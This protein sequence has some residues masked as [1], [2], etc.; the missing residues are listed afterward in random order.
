MDHRAWQPVE[1]PPH[2]ATTGNT[3]ILVGRSVGLRGLVSSALAGER[4]NPQR[5]VA[6]DAACGGGGL[7][8]GTA[9]SHVPM[10]SNLSTAGRPAGPS[11]KYYCMLLG[12]AWPDSSSIGKVAR[13]CGG[14][15]R[16]HVCTITSVIGSSPQNPPVCRYPSS[17]GPSVQ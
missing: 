9:S 1:S 4:I 8:A 17:K 7:W 13:E 12:E 3:D 11:L 5:R 14:N 16:H 6:A 15:A 2:A 10:L